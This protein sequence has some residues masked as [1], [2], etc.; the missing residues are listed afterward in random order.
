MSYGLENGWISANTRHLQ[1]ESAPTGEPVSDISM[2]WIASAFSLT[3]A[4]GVP[5][6]AYIANRFGSK[7]AVIILYGPQMVSYC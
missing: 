7:R 4:L 3:A 5:M 1:A 6:F 2:S